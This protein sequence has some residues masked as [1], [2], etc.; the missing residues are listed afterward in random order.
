MLFRSYYDMFHSTGTF[1]VSRIS[2]PEID[3]LLDEARVSLDS[4]RRNEIYIQVNQILSEEA[5]Y[6]PLYFSASMLVYNPDLQGA[7]A[8]S[9]QNYQYKDLSW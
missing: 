5:Y 6:I 1:N 8:V 3:A 7:H 2:N 9:T 4:E